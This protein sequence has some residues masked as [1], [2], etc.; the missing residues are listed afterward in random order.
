MR[1]ARD[2]CS[3]TD[4]F[5]DGQVNDRRRQG[6]DRKAGAGGTLRALVLVSMLLNSYKPNPLLIIEITE[7]RQPFDISN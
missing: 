1:V 7:E 4:D 3:Q 5:R 6:D 2:S